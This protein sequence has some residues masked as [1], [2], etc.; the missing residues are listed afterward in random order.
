MTQEVSD[1]LLKNYFNARKSWEGW[2][3]LNNI[4][5]KVS[6]RN[7]RKYVDENKL[8]FYLRYLLIKDLHI[9]LYKIIKDNSNNSD[10]IFKLLKAFNSNKAKLHLR[11]LND[12]STEIKSLTNIRDKFY[13]HLD[14]DYNEFITNFK[15]EDY[16]KIFVLIEEAIK[17]LGKESELIKIL[18]K[19]PSRDEFELII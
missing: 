10:N 17:I 5:L 16:Y 13:A 3:Y 15:I 8:M 19:I 1:R 11:K 7:V 18:N 4:D 14:P 12:F 2:C 9:E 6:K